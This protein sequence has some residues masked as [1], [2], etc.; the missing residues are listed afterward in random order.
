MKQV[1]LLSRTI[2]AL[3]FPLIVTIVIL[4]SSLSEVNIGGENLTAVETLTPVYSNLSF[5][6]GQIFSRIAVPLFFFI[7]GF[8]FFFNVKQF[9]KDVYLQKIK[10]RISTLLVPYLFWNLLMIVLYFCIQN[11]FPDITSGRTKLMCDYS[12]SDWLACFW[13]YK[14]INPFLA[15]THP[16]SPILG[17]FW[18]I[19]DLMVVVVFTPLLYWL[20]S[21]LRFACVMLLGLFWLF[22]CEVE[23]AGF[24]P[25]SFFFFTFGAYCSLNKIDFAVLC[26]KYML[27]SGGGICNICYNFDEDGQ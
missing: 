13:D 3:R 26:R 27:I 15:E 2:S 10:S 21:K 11:F 19:R 5:L 25:V 16:I 6:L 4:H 8:L 12:F 9:T 22:F 24:S 18:F 7:S 14:S 20:L 23:I 1:S 17:Q